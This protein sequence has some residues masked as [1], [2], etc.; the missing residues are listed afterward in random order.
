MRL[1]SC[2][3]F[4]V[5]E[6]VSESVWAAAGS[7]Q[8]PWR[9]FLYDSLSLC[10]HPATTDIVCTLTVIMS[11]IFSLD[12][13]DGQ[14]EICSIICSIATESRW[15]SWLL[16]SNA[17]NEE[18]RSF[19]RFLQIPVETGATTPWTF[20][21]SSASLTVYSNCF[22]WLNSFCRGSLSHRNLSCSSC[23]WYFMR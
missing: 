13:T 6:W 21:N 22:S 16:C 11:S 8:S 23:E 19:S 1:G 4:F 7:V 10:D 15:S 17:K 3:C 20:S 9:R 2:L 5:V 18:F 12:S 14:S